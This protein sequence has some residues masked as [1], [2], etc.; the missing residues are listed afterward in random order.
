MENS[1]S[2]ILNKAIAE[3]TSPVEMMSFCKSI[4]ENASKYISL[5][6]SIL[7]NHLWFYF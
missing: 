3:Q 7:R 6:I 2:Q 4:N 1:F 5:F